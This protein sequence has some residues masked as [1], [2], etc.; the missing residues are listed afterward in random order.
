[1]N[2]LAKNYNRK[3]ISFKRGKGSYLFSADGK[4]YLDMISGIAVNSLGHAHPKLVKTIRDQSKKLW[5]VSNAFQIPEG[6]KLAKKICKKT[7]AD[8]VMFQNSGAEA[9]E[10]AIKV[11]RRYFYSIGKPNKNRILCIKN[12]FHGRTIAA[13]FA[14][15]SKK[16]TEGFG[17][18]VPGFDHIEFRKFKPRFPNIR[19]KIKKNTAAIDRKSVV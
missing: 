18:K 10:A 7:F 3:K 6:E 14:S 1:M 2:N 11:A 16:M 12:S 9:T 13:I 8:Y 19:S 15:G 5:H 4:K 17:P